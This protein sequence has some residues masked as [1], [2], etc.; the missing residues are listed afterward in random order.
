MHPLDPERHSRRA[1][2]QRAG[3]LALVGT[4]APLALNLAAIGEAAAFSATDYKALVCVFLFGGNDYANTVVPFDESRHA[5]YSLLRGGS[6]GGSL[7]IPRSA[8]TATELKPTQAL[9]DG[10]R[11]ALAPEMPEMA[12]LFDQGRLAVQLNIGP[13]VTPLT[14]QQYEARVLAQPP[15]LFSHN[16]Q[17]SLWQAQGAEGSTRGWGGNIG[18]LALSAN[19]QSMFTCI[20]VSG[21]AVF[22][23][24]QNALQYQCSK[25]GAVNIEAVRGSSWGQFLWVPEMRSSFE[26]MLQRT[27]NHALAES[28]AAV[29]RRSLAA[30]QRVTSAIAPVQLA[31]AFAAGN[32]LA[33]QMNM[34]ARLIAGRGALGVKR[35]V[36]FV[37]LE[38]FDVHDNMATRQPA[39]LRRLSQALGAFDGALGELGLRNHV[40]T[41]TASDFGRTLSVNGDGT[42]HGWGGHRFILGGAVKGTAFYGRPAP[43][44]VT[45]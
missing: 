15:K 14:R 3:Q 42:D 21:N 37:S 16:D 4:A 23:S 24:G 12:A 34:V 32:S 1:F 17:Q 25:A 18:D 7:V 36:F 38:G 41:F 2:L 28:Y 40:T 13:L 19:G 27:Q 31:T 6:S 5:T 20:S 44:S 11:Y 29:T 39:L 10:T 8:L 33:E 22:L 26:Q 43:L 35:Q 30:E 45:G 9:A